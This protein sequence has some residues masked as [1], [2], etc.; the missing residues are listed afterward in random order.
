MLFLVGAGNLGQA[1]LGYKEFDKYGLNI[2]AA[3]DIS[4][5]KIS[6][7]F[8]GKR[9]FPITKLGDLAKRMNIKIGIITTNTA[10]AQ[11]VADMM[12]DAGIKGIWNFAP[13][14]INVP[15]D[16]IVQNENLAT[17]LSILLSKIKDD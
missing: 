4:P 14:Y 13:T 12:V 7:E 5:F 8:F 6:K 2:V 10:S 3:F 16:V 17:S 15:D 11:K 1:L 9:V